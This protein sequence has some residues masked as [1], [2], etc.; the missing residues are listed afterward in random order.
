MLFCLFH[1]VKHPFGFCIHFPFSFAGF[2][3]ND[4]P[5]ESLQ[6]YFADIFEERFKGGMIMSGANA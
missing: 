1:N 6:I 5:F 3:S 4:N 2:R